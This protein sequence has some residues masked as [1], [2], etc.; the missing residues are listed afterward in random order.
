M[1]SRD[2]SPSL[3]KP[4]RASALKYF[5]GNNRQLLWVSVLS[6]TVVTD[7]SEAEWIST[8]SPWGSSSPALAHMFQETLNHCPKHKAGGLSFAL[9]GTKQMPYSNY[10]VKLLKKVLNSSIYAAAFSP[11][12]LT[13]SRITSSV[14]RGKPL[15]QPASNQ[16]AFCVIAGHA[17]SGLLHLSAVS[18]WPSDSLMKCPQSQWITT[19]TSANTPNNSSNNQPSHL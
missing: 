16:T 13:P 9:Q 4:I 2:A 6:A 11:H 18:Y 19:P 15:E 3:I 12:T 8:A 1:S 14:K 10:C 5:H 7:G 17:S